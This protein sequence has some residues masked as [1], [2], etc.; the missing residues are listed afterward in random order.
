MDDTRPAQSWLPATKQLA[1][2]GLAVQRV[3]Q[4]RGLTVPTQYR[5]HVALRDR[6]SGYVVVLPLPDG[7]VTPTMVGLARQ[8][9]AEN[10][11]VSRLL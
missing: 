11:R 3:L 5:H 7:L 10:A 1:A 2:A 9:A 6:D 4:Q 8:A